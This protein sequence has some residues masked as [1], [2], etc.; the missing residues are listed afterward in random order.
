M[1][2][3]TTKTGVYLTTYT[4][5]EIDDKIEES[6]DKVGSG[7]SVSFMDEIKSFNKNSEYFLNKKDAIE[8]VGI[9][10]KKGKEQK[11][12]LYTNYKGTPFGLPVAGAQLYYKDPVLSLKS[13]FSI[14]ATDFDFDNDFFHVR[15]VN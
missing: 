11:H 8:L 5:K 9:E 1:K 3:I 15:I 7:S 6:I 2:E 14:A 4:Q 10:I 13:A 12:D